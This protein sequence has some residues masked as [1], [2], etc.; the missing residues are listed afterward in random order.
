MRFLRVAGQIVQEREMRRKDR[1]GY[2]NRAIKNLSRFRII[3][4]SWN[5]FAAVRWRLSI[6]LGRRSKIFHSEFIRLIGFIHRRSYILNIF[7]GIHVRIYIVRMI[8]LSLDIG[9][10]YRSEMEIKN[11]SEFI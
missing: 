10:I 9:R 2:G 7:V 4:L 6:E 11:L 8:S 5:I 3:S 1:V